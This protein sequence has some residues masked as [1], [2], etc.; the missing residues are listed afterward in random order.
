MKSH[1]IPVNPSM[2][3]DTLTTHEAAIASAAARSAELGAAASLLAPGQRR[4]PHTQDFMMKNGVNSKI[5]NHCDLAA[6]IMELC[7]ITCDDGDIW[8]WKM[9]CLNLN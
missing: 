8:W 9:E 1:E 5:I 4:Q 3:L 6:W 7:G 2:F